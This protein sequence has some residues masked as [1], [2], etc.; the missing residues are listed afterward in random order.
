M[1]ATR[2]QIDDFVNERNFLFYGVSSVKGKFGNL[3][4]KHL[5]DNGYNVF[6]VHPDLKQVI[7]IDCNKTPA[8]VNQKMNNAVILLSPENT[9]KVVGELIAYGIKKIWIQQRCESERA[10][11]MC[12]E[13]NIE[14]ISEECI[15]MF[16]GPLTII[17]NIHKWINKVSGKLPA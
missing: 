15:M 5:N 12:E 8:D 16:A 14:V 3:V 11:K 17:H 2:K 4:L 6:P 7:G 9:E 1:K 13:N 10:L